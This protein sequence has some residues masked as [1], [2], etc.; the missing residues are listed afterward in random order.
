MA[1]WAH[2]GPTSWQQRE[3]GGLQR[4][5]GPCIVSVKGCC[6]G[7]VREACLGA[8]LGDALMLVVYVDTVAAA[9]FAYV[10]P[11]SLAGVLVHALLVALSSALRALID[12]HAPLPILSQPQ[13]RPVDT[14]G[15]AQT[16][17]ITQRCHASNGMGIT[18]SAPI[19]AT[20]VCTEIPCRAASLSVKAFAEL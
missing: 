4:R 11:P 9:A 8:D 1:H 18:R 6:P 13:S 2:E 15:V 12:V 3:L 20:K 10:L 17:R 5:R 14:G 16:D 7:S 19:S